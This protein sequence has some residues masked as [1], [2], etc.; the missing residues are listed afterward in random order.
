MVKLKYI[1]LFILIQVINIPLFIIGIPV[2]AV[3]AWGGFSYFAEDNK[4]H[5]PRWAYIW[6]NPE[7]GVDGAWYQ[8]A[9]KH[10][11]YAMNEFIWS[12]LRNPVNNLRYVP[13][14]SGIGRPYWR[15]TWGAV[16][17]GFYAHAG[18][19]A[20]GFPVLSAGRNNYAY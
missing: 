13:G 12:A 9:N 17:G 19:N 1:L 18:W 4:Y 10:R 5:W 14:V 2:C 7:D 8:R 16:P 11:S 20:S 6:D 3:L 15:K